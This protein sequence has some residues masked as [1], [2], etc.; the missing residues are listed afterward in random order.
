VRLLGRR[1]ER[2][3]LDRVLEAARNGH[4][5]VLAAYGEPGVGKTAL[6]DCAI[7]SGADFRCPRRPGGTCRRISLRGHN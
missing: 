7:E 3:A 5:G 1:R 6:L 2:E 4:G